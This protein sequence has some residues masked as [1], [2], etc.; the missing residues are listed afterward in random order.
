MTATAIGQELMGTDGASAEVECQ[1]AIQVRPLLV[2]GDVARILGV[3]ERTVW[4]LA[5]RARG[6]AGG[7][8]KPLR[9]G[10]QVLRWRYEDV[11]KYL[12]E[13]SRN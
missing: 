2:V 11:Q 7:F 4:R 3:G 9:I 1:P 10:P 13:L 5:S 6:G 8:P 12:Q